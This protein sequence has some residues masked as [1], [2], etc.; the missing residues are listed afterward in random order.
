MEDYEDYYGIIGVGTKASSE[1]IKRAYRDQCFIL[2]PDR[3]EGVPESA[4]KR[5]EGQLKKINQAY[6]VLKDPQSRQQYDSCRSAGNGRTSQNNG[7]TGTSQ[8]SVPKPKPTVDPQ[9][10][11][12][13]DVKAGEIKIATFIVDNKGGPL[14]CPQ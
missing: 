8:N 3:M 2:H 6:D 9:Y 11:R 13:H 14:T 10:I 4:K 12:F 1:E 7:N 5:A